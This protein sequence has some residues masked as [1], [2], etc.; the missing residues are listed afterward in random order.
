MP[1]VARRVRN[2]RGGI[3]RRRRRF[4]K[5]YKSY[6]S[7]AYTA[8]KGVRL[9]KG[10]V[11]V[12]KKFF[13]VAQSGLVLS[14]ATI[15]PLNNMAAGDDHNQRNGNSILAK[16]IVGKFTITINPTATTS[17]TRIMVIMDLSNQ[18][19]APGLG[20]ILQ[21][22]TVGQ[23]IV[24][25]KNSDNTDRF[26]TLYDKTFTMS[27]NGRQTI[28]PKMY[29][30]INTHLKYNNTSASVDTNAIYLVLLSDQDLSGT[31]PLATWHTRLAFYDN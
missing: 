2:K 4:Y 8:Y 1:K 24:S 17:Y 14:S 10:L 26:W 22:I 23:G 9:L 11:N 27:D 12:E 7:M 20:D 21:T 13:D 5:Q 25:P 15:A 30:P 29:V 3:S 28:S 18:G 19:L 31:A 6:R 16:Y